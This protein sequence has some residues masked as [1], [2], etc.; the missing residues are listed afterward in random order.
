MNAGHHSDSWVNRVRS[1]IINVPIKDTNGRTI[2]VLS[3]PRE[4]DEDGYMHFD[5]PKFAKD[6]TLSKQIKPDVVVYATGYQRSFP[7]LDN[8]Y[9]DVVQCNVR[10]IYKS[11]DVTCGFIGFV[12]PSL[13]NGC[14]PSI[15][16]ISLTENRCHSSSGGITSPIMGAATC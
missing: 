13:G 11:D 3:W 9:P 1:K 7:F 16:A 12:R 4:I 2:D 6:S 14:Q 10:G 5:E 15:L 8:Q